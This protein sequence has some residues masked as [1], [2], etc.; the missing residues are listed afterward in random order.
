MFE[1]TRCNG[2]F[3]S[4]DVAA[5]IAQTCI[6][7]KISYNNTKIQ[8]LLYCVY[9]VLLAKFNIQICNEPPHAWPYG[10][11]FPKVFSYIHKGKSIE[12]Y[13]KRLQCEL[14]QEEQ[15]FIEI[16]IKFFGKH[17][18][19]QLSNWSHLSGSPWAMIV[20]EEG[21]GWNTTLRNEDIAHY[22][23]RYVLANE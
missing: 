5:F 8:K 19:S 3:D 2:L 6:K 14:S 16:I 1:G 20:R 23:K 12:E 4:L 18:A 9:G 15:A 10:P 22:F 21:A 7:N 17:S 11:V 13:S